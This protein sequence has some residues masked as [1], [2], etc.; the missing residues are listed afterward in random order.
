MAA[1]GRA[2]GGG[3][4]EALSHSGEEPGNPSRVRGKGGVRVRLEE[5]DGDIEED[6]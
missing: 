5:G 6:E 4:A 3:S 1:A 2:S